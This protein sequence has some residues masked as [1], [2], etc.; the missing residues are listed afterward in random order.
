MRNREENAIRNKK[1]HFLIMILFFKVNFAIFACSFFL[2]FYLFIFRKR[3]KGSKRERNINVWLTLAY[4]LLGNVAHN[5][6]MGPRTGNQTGDPLVRRPAL[7]PLSY[8]S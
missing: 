6:G 1:Y 4:P 3:G 8:A 7:K 5:P 2:R